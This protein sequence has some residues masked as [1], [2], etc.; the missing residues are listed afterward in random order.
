RRGARRRDQ[1]AAPA[2]RA[3]APPGRSTPRPGRADL[4]R[5]AARLP[6]PRPPLRALGGRGGSPPPG[7]LPLAGG[8][9]E[10]RPSPHRRRGAPIP[11]DEPQASG[12]PLG[13][14]LA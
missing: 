8:G 7:G 2:P 14:R 1:R 4:R 5:G 9:R 11:R 13:G 12:A 6:P 3:G 10:P